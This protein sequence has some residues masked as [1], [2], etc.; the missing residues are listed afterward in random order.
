LE[1]GN[2][3]DSAEDLGPN[4]F[5]VLED[6]L[7][8]SGAAGAQRPVITL[9]ENSGRGALVVGQQDVVS[10]LEIDSTVAHTDVEITGGT[11]DGV[12]ARSSAAAPAIACEHIAGLVR[13]S[14]CLSSG[15]GG[16]ALGS[17]QNLTGPA[18]NLADPANVRLTVRNVTA[19]ASGTGS[20]GLDYAMSGILARP[21]LEV[22]AIAVLARGK[23]IDVK[24]EGLSQDQSPRDGAEVSVTLHNSDYTSEQGVTDAGGGTAEVT[25]H[26]SPTNIEDT[27]LLAADGFH[28]LAGSPTINKGAVDAQSG[29]SDVDGGE[30]VIGD[31][32]DIGADEVALSS[33]TAILCTPTTIDAGGAPT[34]CVVTVRGPLGSTSAPTGSVRLTTDGGGTFA[35]EGHCALAPVPG[36]LLEASCPIS[37]TA[38]AGRPSA[39]HTVRAQYAG[40]RAHDSSSGTVSVTVKGVNPPPPPPPPPPHEAPQTTL[41]KHPK[42]KGTK[43]VARFSFSADQAGSSFECKLDKA[44]FKPCTSPL[45]VSVK[46]GAHTLQVRAVSSQGVRDATPAKFSWRVLAP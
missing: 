32:A 4:G 3:S 35:D 9:N 7:R 44:A 40:D 37:Y 16:V 43:R 27:P 29:E 42:S 22:D 10:G 18:V 28:E 31:A 20:F 23:A 30:R 46:R 25:P 39:I 24:A 17:R 12:I 21:T 2:Y 15:N 33:A 1:P 13:N 45:K 36:H 19:L 11:I 6:G 34:L 14:A 41:L 26:G 38:I 5:V 8:V